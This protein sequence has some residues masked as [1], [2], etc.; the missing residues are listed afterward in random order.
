[1]KT[2]Q[3]LSVLLCML[4]TGFCIPHAGAADSGVHLS[5]PQTQIFEGDTLDVTVTLGSSLQNVASFDWQLRF[6]DTLFT[7]QSAVIGECHADM[8]VSNLK[9]DADGAYY[10]IS[11]VDK[12]SKGET[13]NAGTVCTLTFRAA[14]GLTADRTGAFS[15]VSEG[16]YDAGFT[17]IPVAAGE[18]VSVAVRR[19]LPEKLVVDKLP[20]KLEYT[21]KSNPDFSG[22]VVRVL[23]NDGHE[24]VI[25]DIQQM[26][27][28]PADGTRVRNGAKNYSV[29]V[30]GLSAAFTMQ[31]RLTVWQWLILVF[32]FGWLWY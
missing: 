31:V 22:M 1:M 11:Y 12:T 24:E 28:K 14:E 6:D 15:L 21:Y 30:Y 17:E 29:T 10:S 18:A 13:L 9:R 20:D 4:L 25:S 26:E 23:F 7:L 16:V 19:V 2:K 8:R 27:I 3:W 5:V 32:L